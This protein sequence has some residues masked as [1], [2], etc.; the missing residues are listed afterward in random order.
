[1]L[2][3]LVFAHRSSGMDVGVWIGWLLEQDNED[4]VILYIYI[5]MLKFFLFFPLKNSPFLAV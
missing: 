5:Y 1:M 2:Y 3:Y 4:M